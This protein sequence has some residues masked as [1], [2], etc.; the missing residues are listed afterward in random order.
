[1]DDLE[2]S[3]DEED[4]QPVITSSPKP[5]GPSHPGNL[6]CFA[7]TC[8]DYE[9]WQLFN[10]IFTIRSV[11]VYSLRACW[12]EEAIENVPPGPPNMNCRHLH[13]ISL[14]IRKTIRLFQKSH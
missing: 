2:S 9:A 4:E 13:M 7:T 11:V 12:I 6:Q 5:G 3:S 8:F 1:M 14:N 10:A